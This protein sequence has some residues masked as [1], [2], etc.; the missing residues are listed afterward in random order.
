[1]EIIDQEDLKSSNEKP[2]NKIMFYP[3]SLGIIFNFTN[4]MNTQN[5]PYGT[6]VLSQAREM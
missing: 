2:D 6:S 3:Y 1:L 5:L 4:I